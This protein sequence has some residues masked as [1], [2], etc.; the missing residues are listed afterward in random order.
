MIQYSLDVGSIVQQ[1]YRLAFG[2]PSVRWPR[3]CTGVAEQNI[4]N[5]QQQ[6]ISNGINEVH[7][8]G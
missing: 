5:S 4:N 6:L 8:I 2:G 1:Q 7:Q 3:L